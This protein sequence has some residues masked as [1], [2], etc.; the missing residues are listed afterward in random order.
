MTTL[1]HQIRWQ[2]DGSLNRRETRNARMV[3][4]IARG[5]AAVLSFEMTFLL[6][7]FA[8]IYKSDTRFAWF[9]IDWTLFFLGINVLQAGWIVTRRGFRLPQPGTTLVAVATLFAG[10][11]AL[12]LL[13]SEGTIYAR[14]KTLHMA[15]LVLWS[16]AGSAL[17]VTHRPERLHRFLRLL[18]FFT[19]WVV[20]ESAWYYVQHPGARLITA[21]GGPG[22]YLGLGRVVGL[23]TL[24]AFY[25]F[26]FVARRPA[27]RLVTGGLLLA[28]LVMSVLIGSRGPLIAT[29]IL[30]IPMVGLALSRK[31]RN[32][33]RGLIAVGLIGA[34]LI[35]IVGVQRHV[36]TTGRLPVTLARLTRLGNE[37][38]RNGGSLTRWDYL[39]ESAR[40]WSQR[41]MFGHGIGSFPVLVNGTDARDYPHNL[42]A[43][44]AAELGLCGLLL[45]AGLFLVALTRRGG[46][47]SSEADGPGIAALSSPG[48]SR[49][50][51][52]A[53][54]CV[55][56]RPLRLLV[57]M[58]LLHAL[59][60]ALISGDIPANRTLFVMLGLSAMTTKEPWC[61]VNLRLTSWK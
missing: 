44:V 12:S 54:H 16:L 55:R 31:N 58:L 47:V 28:G 6:F 1:P 11:A 61:R 59:L 2:C 33:S 26:A 29:A 21:L 32:G 53:T 60:N 57:L 39:V 22:S 15:T 41:P 42:I 49:W 45:L 51:D 4:G 5:A 38:I 27:A 50:S 25:E 37:T 35:G 13:W 17:I 7:V 43:E 14:A 8:G 40:L 30:L 19:A 24:I 36:A 23:G 3:H 46:R 18:L 52:P 10:Y 34:S 9:P 20:L 56:N 48:P